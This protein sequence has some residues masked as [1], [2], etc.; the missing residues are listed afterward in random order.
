MRKLDA[1]S[2]K[3]MEGHLQTC[4][5]VWVDNNNNNNNN[6][7]IHALIATRL[8]FLSKVIENVISIRIIDKNSVD[9]F[10]STYRAGHRCETAFFRVYNDIVTTVG[11]G[12]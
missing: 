9:N 4:M 6:K 2:L 1:T 3:L 12:N 11:K 8:S 10:Q 7:R 5:D